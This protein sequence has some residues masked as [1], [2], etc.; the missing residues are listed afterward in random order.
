MKAEKFFKELAD[1][2]GFHRSD[3]SRVKKMHINSG[4]GYVLRERYAQAN[5]KMKNTVT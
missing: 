5:P 3:K 4:M 1:E 2:W